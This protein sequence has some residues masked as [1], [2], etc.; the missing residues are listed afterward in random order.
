MKEYERYERICKIWKALG[1]PGP[2][3]D[4]RPL[5]PS[6]SAGKGPRLSAFES[7]VVQA[8]VGCTRLHHVTPLSVVSLYAR[9]D[10]LASKL[11]LGRIDLLWFTVYIDIAMQRLI[12]ARWHFTECNQLAEQKT[13]MRTTWHGIMQPNPNVLSGCLQLKARCP[14]GSSWLGDKNTQL[15]SLA[16]RFG[17]AA[18]DAWLKNEHFSILSCL[19]WIDMI[20][21]DGSRGA[22]TSGRRRRRRRRRRR[23]PKTPE[24]AE[25]ARR[26]RRRPKMPEDARRRRRRPKTPKTPKTPEDAEDARRRRRRPKTPED[27]EDARRRRRRRRRPKTPKTPEDAEDARRRP[28]TPKTPE[29]AEDARRRR[30]RPKTPED[31]AGFRTGV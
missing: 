1:M 6:P 19:I 23:P 5:S 18:T 15:A 27:A 7:Q 8:E 25:D 16:R 30:R 24:D 28:K 11:S 3:L 20:C 13:D 9:N 29:D 26:R 10:R 4:T 17:V 31:A 12:D 21:I 22:P 2:C 14:E